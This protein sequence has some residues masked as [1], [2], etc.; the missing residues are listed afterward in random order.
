MLLLFVVVSSPCLFLQLAHH[1]FLFGSFSV[2]AACQSSSLTTALCQLTNFFVFCLRQTTCSLGDIT[3]LLNTPVIDW[4]S[5]K[6]NIYVRAW[7][8]ATGYCV[9][10][11][12][13]CCYYFD[14]WGKVDFILLVTFTVL[15]FYT[16]L[17]IIC[18][19][20]INNSLEKISAIDYCKC[21]AK[22][23][24]PPPPCKDYDFWWTSPN[25]TLVYTKREYRKS[26]LIGIF[27]AVLKCSP[28]AGFFLT[29]WQT[30]RDLTA[31]S[32]HLW[33]DCWAHQQ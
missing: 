23:K 21:G 24:Q 29:G 9:K 18:Y 20:L 6:H 19:F 13:W 26:N 17:S 14:K 28:I 1:W 27:S 25:F 33:A 10:V 4:I 12:D 22:S 32:K 8:K 3:I 16:I 7:G 2:L 15:T 31:N 30:W 11:N 5:C